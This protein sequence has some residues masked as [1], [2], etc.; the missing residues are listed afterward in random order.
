M[1]AARDSANSGVPPDH[2]T[3]FASESAA[4]AH[5][6][7]A[8]APVTAATAEITD[9]KTPRNA[10]PGAE[11]NESE[12]AAKIRPSGCK[13]RVTAAGSNAIPVTTSD[14]TVGAG[15]IMLAEY[16]HNTPSTRRSRNRYIRPAAVICSAT[17]S[18]SD[19]LDPGT[20]DRPT[21]AAPT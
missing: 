9:S 10:A 20:G 11:H 21:A 5:N 15:T 6:V 18:A 3:R 19:P 17:Q 13:Y 16:H 12:V 14:S 8:L 4:T 7:R 2:S 1:S